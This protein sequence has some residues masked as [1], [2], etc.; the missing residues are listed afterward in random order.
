MISEQNSWP[1]SAPE[2]KVLVP[3]EHHITKY[4]S[5]HLSGTQSAI[6]RLQMCQSDIHLL[7]LTTVILNTTPQAAAGC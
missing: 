7:V 1:A 3:M 4:H 2:E 6:T 5:S